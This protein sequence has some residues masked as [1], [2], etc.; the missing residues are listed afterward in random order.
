MRTMTVKAVSKPSG[1]PDAEVAVSVAEYD[2]EVAVVA[3]IRAV[4]SIDSVVVARLSMS[5]NAARDLAARL[6]AAAEG[7]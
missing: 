6:V 3:N 7:K 5:P 4:T 2:G 1:I